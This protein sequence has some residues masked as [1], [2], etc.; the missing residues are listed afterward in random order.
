MPSGTQPGPSPLPGP[1]NVYHSGSAAPPQP[2]PLRSSSNTASYRDKGQPKLTDPIEEQI[3]YMNPFMPQK[4]A[5]TAFK[6]YQNPYQPAPLPFSSLYT[7][8]PAPPAPPAPFPVNAPFLHPPIPPPDTD[9]GVETDSG[10]IA[11]LARLEWVDYAESHPTRRKKKCDAFVLEVLVGEPDLLSARTPGLRSARFRHGLSSSNSPPP[12]T[13]ETNVPRPETGKFKARPAREK[14]GVLP[15]EHT[16]IP[17]R[18]RIN[19]MQLIKILELVSG[20]QLPPSLNGVVDSAVIVRPF[21][22]LVEHEDMIRRWY[23]ELRRRFTPRTD[24]VNENDEDGGD[25]EIRNLMDRFDGTG[26]IESPTAL[27]HLH[28]LL[29]LIDQDI[30]ENVDSIRNAKRQ[31][32]SFSD[33]WH[34]FSPGDTVIGDEGRQAYRILSIRSSQHRAAEIRIDGTMSRETSVLHLLC[35]H[36]DFDGQQLGPVQTTFKIHSFDRD[37]HIT[38]LPVYPFECSGV[39]N[40]HSELVARGKI[41][42]DMAGIRHMHYAGPTLVARDDID[43][44]VVIDVERVDREFVPRI[45]NLVGTTAEEVRQVT[46]LCHGGCCYGEYIFSE[47]TIE[48]KRDARYMATLVPQSRAQLPSLAVYPRTLGEMKTSETPITDDEFLI[49][50]HR[51]FGFILHRRKWGRFQVP[52]LCRMRYSPTSALTM[53][54]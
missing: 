13:R 5:A 14:F 20:E 46:A 24:Q 37:K 19:S 50:S 41:F 17:E 21:K 52:L 18:V 31:K 7:L 8:P 34:L 51:V 10:L 32:V 48:A 54:Y 36:I 4:A 40:L 16:T 49:M 26:D 27:Q 9:D 33:L 12:Q 47:M 29:E 45:E 3:D 53:R 44:Q 39:Q 23:D 15:S 28:C 1:N 6:P 42:F 22:M 11:S 43:S 35:T 30:K 2:P 38:S 25:W